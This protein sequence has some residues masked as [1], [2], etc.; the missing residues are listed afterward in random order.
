MLQK[1]LALFPDP[2]KHLLSGHAVMRE[3]LRNIAH[4]NAHC[5]VFFHADQ[6]GDI[7]LFIISPAGF[8]FRRIDNAFLFVKMQRVAFNFAYNGC[9]V[10]I[11]ADR[12]AADRHSVS[13]TDR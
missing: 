3:L 6:A 11:L 4:G 5:A 13:Q 2:A 7:R 8:H 10:V 12:A 1:I 9:F